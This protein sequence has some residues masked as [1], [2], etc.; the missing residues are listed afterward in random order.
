MNIK[1]L[2]FAFL[3]VGLG[4]EA[5]A[6]EQKPENM[7]Q[8]PC[9][10]DL[11]NGQLICG[12]TGKGEEYYCEAGACSHGCFFVR[13]STAGDIHVCVYQGTAP[14]CSQAENHVHSHQALKK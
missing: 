7:S 13:Y 12:G 11:Y 1:I 4:R 3:M 14:Y 8:D 2:F 6:S 10:I 5:M 9:T